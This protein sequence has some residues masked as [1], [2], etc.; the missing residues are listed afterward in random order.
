MLTGEIGE[1]TR[2]SLA[3]IARFGAREAPRVAVARP[4]L[5]PAERLMPYL[6]QIDEARWYSNFGPLLT[7]FE[8]R[9]ADRFA[10]GTQVITAV[11]ATQALTLTLQ[12]MDLPRGGLCALPAWTF[13]ATA[14]AVAAAGLTPWFV[15]VDLDTWMLTPAGVEAALAFAPGP[16][17]AALPVSAFG[18]LP[19]L[20]GWSAFR[21]RTGVPVLVDAAAAFDTIAEADLP[22]VVSLHATKVLGIGEGGFLATTDAAL[23]ERVRQ[24]TTYG[25][26]GSREAHFPATNAKLSEYAAAVGLAA[27]DGWDADRLLFALAGQRLRVG[28]ALTPE[29]VFQSGW[30]LDWVTSVCAVRTPDGAAH[31]VDEALASAGID[32]RRWWG[33]GCHRAPAFQACPRT[34]LPNTERLAASTV[35]LPFS[36]DLT[37]EEVDRTAAAVLEALSA[38]RWEPAP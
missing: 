10:P 14:H 12:A 26:H 32:T 27:L 19:D 24:F 37:A 8:G 36:I 22:A 11:N 34:E 3:A 17:V 15:D 28:F 35:G 2:L 25:F 18:A 9:L 20:A 6:S 33:E 23:A 21:A 38:R 13:V 31:I 29:I 16:V 30:A 7:R 1:E 4:R 5:P